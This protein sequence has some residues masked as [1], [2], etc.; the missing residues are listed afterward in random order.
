MTRVLFV[1]I[2]FSDSVS[3]H[4]HA[5]PSTGQEVLVFSED[6]IS[7]QIPAHDQIFVLCPA[8]ITK[9]EHYWYLKN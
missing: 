1:C 4:F 6:L 8:E 3:E 9:K 5:K 2:S 7:H